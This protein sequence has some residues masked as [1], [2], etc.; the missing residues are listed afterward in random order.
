MTNAEQCGTLPSLPGTGR[1]D[2][3]AAAVGGVHARSVVEGAATPTNVIPRL[4]RGTAVN[5]RE[6]GDRRCCALSDDA[7]KRRVIPMTPAI[8]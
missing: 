5:E 4:D 8:P 2:R 1:G 6:R 7:N 3:R